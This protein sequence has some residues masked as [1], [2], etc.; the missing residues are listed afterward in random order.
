[1]H[2]NTEGGQPVLRPQNSHGEQDSNPPPED[3]LHPSAETVSAA[4]SCAFADRA[5]FCQTVTRR[6]AEWRRGGCGFSVLLV[7]IDNRHEL[8]SRFGMECEPTLLE[9]MARLLEAYSPDMPERCHY[10]AGTFAVLLPAADFDRA[11]EI[12]ERLRNESVGFELPDGNG[13]VSLR[14]SVGVVPSRPGDNTVDVLRRAEDALK[15]ASQ[16]VE[17]A[18]A[19]TGSFL[20][21]R[22]R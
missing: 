18:S 19:V 21:D 9:A 2:S 1:V 5:Q 16:V 12:T 13:T 14:F 17:S 4:P 8:V 10:K 15:R 6:L 7:R 11:A 20:H 3:R 22:V